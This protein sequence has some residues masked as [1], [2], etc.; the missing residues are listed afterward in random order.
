MV[1]SKAGK[2]RNLLTQEIPKSSNKRNQS[3]LVCL[4]TNDKVNKKSWVL[5]N[6]SN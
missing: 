1:N 3:V 2:F 5:K 4:F 6:K